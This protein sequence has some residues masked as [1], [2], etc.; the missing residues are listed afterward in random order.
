[1]IKSEEY[2]NKKFHHDHTIIDKN[3]G[4]DIPGRSKILKGSCDLLKFHKAI[5]K[6]DI[7]VAMFIFL[8]LKMSEF[9]KVFGTK[10]VSKNLSNF[11]FKEAGISAYNQEC[12]KGY[13]TY[14]FFL[15]YSVL[16]G[17]YSENSCLESWNTGMVFFLFAENICF[18]GR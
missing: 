18:S 4:P 13:F 16:R 7:F 11:D 12:G 1:M 6:S 15:V 5:F 14:W 2:N 17:C 8:S 3:L 9:V 10:L